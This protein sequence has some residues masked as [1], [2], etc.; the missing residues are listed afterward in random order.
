M[1]D[2][3]AIIAEARRWLGTPFRDS[4]GLLGQ[5]VDCLWFC[6]GVYQALGHVPKG[7]IPPYSPQFLMHQTDD[8]FLR[9]IA[10][11]TVEI[12]PDEAQMGDMVIFK[13]GRCYSHSAL[14]IAW[15]KI[16]HAHKPANCVLEDNAINNQ[17]LA[18]DAHGERP[19]KFFTL[20]EAA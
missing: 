4:C 18:R 6:Y 19:R 1:I 8:P 5:G 17:L 9:E 13:F 16:I 14:I 2:R 20:R 11:Y 7:I 12:A 3:P 10:P 15:P